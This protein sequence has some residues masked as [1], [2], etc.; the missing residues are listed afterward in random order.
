MWE[1]PITQ[2]NLGR[3]RNKCRWFTLGPISKRLMCGDVGIGAMA[4]PLDIADKVQK[5]LRGER[6]SSGK[7]TVMAGLAIMSAAAAVAFVA[8]RKK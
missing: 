2:E 8:M 7:K 1:H 4:E 5:I 3:L 6:E